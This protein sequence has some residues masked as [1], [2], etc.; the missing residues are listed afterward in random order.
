M[1]LGLPSGTQRVT[2][3]SRRSM[4]LSASTKSRPS[5]LTLSSASMSSWSICF[6]PAEMKMSQGAAFCICVLSEPEES[7]LNTSVT[8][9]ATSAYMPWISV[10]VSSM[11]AAA[12]TTSST[13]SAAGSVASGAS[14]CGGVSVP[15]AARTRAMANARSRARVFFRFFM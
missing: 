2:R 14:V 7:K 10:S 6:W 15:Q 12:K 11:L 3:F 5:V 1:P 9:G 13:G 8:F 4:R